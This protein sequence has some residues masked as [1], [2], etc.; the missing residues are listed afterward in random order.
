[1]FYQKLK[2][3]FHSHPFWLIVGIIIVIITVSGSLYQFVG[4]I[5]NL[6][7]MYSSL[8]IASQISL[9]TV[10]NICATII[11]LLLVTSYLTVKMEKI[12]NK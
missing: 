11:F 1:M 4:M 7:G 8:D 9:M 2:E 12:G 10:I 3:S 5:L 6:Y